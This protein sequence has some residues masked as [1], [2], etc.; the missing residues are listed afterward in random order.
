MEPK[1]IKTSQSAQKSKQIAMQ[2]ENS[3]MDKH[4]AIYGDDN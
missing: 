4:K 1:Y 3:P 2:L